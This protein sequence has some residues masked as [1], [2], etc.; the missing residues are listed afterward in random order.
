MR[1]LPRLHLLALV[2]LF[3]GAL[4]FSAEAR[5]ASALT[6]SFTLG[7][8]T[9]FSNPSSIAFG[10]DGRLYVA[11]QSTI[12]AYTLDATGLMV[13]DVEPIATGQSGVLGIAFDPT[14]APSPAVL[15]ASRQNTAATDSY[16]GV[17]ST[18]TGPTWTRSDVIT[19]LPSSAPFTNHF[20]NG[21]AFDENGLL[22]MANGSNTDAGIQS[23]NY[24]ETPLSAAILVADVNDAQF[25]GT[26]TYSPAG[27]PVDDE[28][29]QT[30]GDVSVFAP[31]TRNPYDLVI[32]SNGRIYATDNGP[33]GPTTSTSCMTTGG[34]VEQNDELNLIEM[35]D[36]YGF[37]NRNRGRSDARQC[38]Y[39]AP[40][41]GSG[42]DFT[43]PIL[44][45]PAHCSCDGIAEYTSSQFGGAMQGDLLI[46]QFVLGNVLR[47]TLSGDGQS[48]VANA[49]LQSGLNNPLDVTVG[50]TG[51]IYIAQFGAG[52][53]SYLDPVPKPVGGVTELP[54]LAAGGS[55]L[56]VVGMVVA[57]AVAA[58]G[59]VVLGLR[60]RL[61]RRRK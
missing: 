6:P 42:V 23:P 51:V 10:P 31:G 29:N 60:V 50:P 38:V 46:A 59:A 9:A 43:A 8:L 37:P 41:E 3:G 17:I 1:R 15:Y 56:G 27:V 49:T 28:V 5:P 52:E 26:I 4:L 53:I 25:D 39:H 11:S 36:Y 16:E 57:S 18:Y 2:I 34:G 54:S 20:T 12:R 14:A 61:W 7:T 30:G 22:Y 44:T 24:P 19:G 45:L 48:V 21:L 55:G 40:S 13:T 47:V 32:H 33:N 35:G 58:A